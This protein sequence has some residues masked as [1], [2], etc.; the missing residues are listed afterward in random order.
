MD[1]GVSTKRWKTLSDAVLFTAAVEQVLPPPCKFSHSRC[2]CVL[3][4]RKHLV[5]TP[6]W[7]PP[8]PTMPVSAAHSVFLALSLNV[9]EPLG[10]VYKKFIGSVGRVAGLMLNVGSFFSLLSHDTTR[11]SCVWAN[12][13][14]LRGAEVA[15]ERRGR[16][17]GESLL[18]FINM[19]V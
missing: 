19:Q 16:V 2:P 11:F 7:D 15:R 12:G 5:R 4:A 9:Y 14:R 6:E 1:G 3:D 13:L 17:A 8:L 18:D 10:T